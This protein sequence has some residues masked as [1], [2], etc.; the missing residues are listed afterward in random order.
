MIFIGI[1]PG[2]T[3]ACCVLDHKGV[4]A[5]FDLPTMKAPEVGPDAKVQR[6]IDGRAFHKLLLQ[7]CPLAEGRPQVII[8]KIQVRSTANSGAGNAL[9]TQGALMRTV[10]AIESVLEC[11]TYPIHYVAPQKW[12][13]MYGVG[14][15]K[16][17][18]LDKARKL[19]PAAAG[20]LAR[21]KDHN[22]AEAVLIAHWGKVELS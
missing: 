21:V 15:E 16:A 2:L 8:E 4:R 3:G 9:Q 1:D 12:K 22:R 11:M 19:Y 7:H 18:A 17:H 5:I 14:S 13:R 20:D 6:K 10:G